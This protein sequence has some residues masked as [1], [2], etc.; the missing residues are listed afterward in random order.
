MDPVSRK[1]NLPIRKE[2]RAIAVLRQSGLRPTRQLIGLTILLFGY[3]DRHVSAEDLFSEAERR[4]IRSSLSSVYR[5]LRRFHEAGLIRK[6]PV[7]GATAYYDT[8]LDEHH[9][10]HVEDDDLLIDV[11]DGEVNLG[12]LPE[13]PSG[14]ELIGAEVVLRLR[15]MDRTASEGAEA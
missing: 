9:H 3:R 1:T 6:V 2:Q 13:P 14:Y 4:G 10:F 8:K 12:P 11:P 5:S 15:R 7:Y